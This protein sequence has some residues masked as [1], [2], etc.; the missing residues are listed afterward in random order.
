MNH[1]LLTLMKEAEKIQEEIRCVEN[2]SKEPEIQSAMDFADTE[3]ANLNLN[4]NLES[5]QG[6]I[7]L[8]LKATDSQF[9]PL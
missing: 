2:S 1:A 7:K 4:L 9:R 3:I 5:V 6:V 8:I